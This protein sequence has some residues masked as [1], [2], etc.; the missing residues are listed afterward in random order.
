MCTVANQPTFT[1]SEEKKD[2]TDPFAPY[3]EALWVQHLTPTHTLLLN[4]YN[5]VAYHVLVV[6][7]RF[8]QQTEALNLQDLEATWQ[9]VQVTAFAARFAAGLAQ[10]RHLNKVSCMCA[11]SASGCTCILQL[12]T[13]VWCK[14]ATQAYPGIVPA[15][16]RVVVVTTCLHFSCVTTQVVPLPLADD[17]AVIPAPLTQLMDQTWQNQGYTDGNIASVPQLPYQNYFSKVFAM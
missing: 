5:V 12:W 6:T 17:P 9:V 4:K 11:G 2:W 1:C 13:R 14:S 8:E 7:K 3:E 16:I 15:H 10:S